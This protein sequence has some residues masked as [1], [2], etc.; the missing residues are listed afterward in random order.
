M[1]FNAPS[2]SPSTTSSAS[3]TSTNSG[4]S[5]KMQGS[6]KSPQQE[7]LDSIKGFSGFSKDRQNVQ[8]IQSSRES[9]PPPTDGSLS[10]L[11]QLKRE[12]EIR[13]AFLSNNNF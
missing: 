10:I 8:P 3:N 1:G 5:P 7:L 4:T 2:S 12:L 13:A 6:V 9:D 11:D